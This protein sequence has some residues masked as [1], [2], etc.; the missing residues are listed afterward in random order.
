MPANSLPSCADMATAAMGGA[1][2]KAEE[3]I[4]A[5]AEVA[6]EME[7][8][9][10]VVAAAEKL[11]WRAIPRPCVPHHLSGVMR[12]HRSPDCRTPKPEGTV[13]CILMLLLSTW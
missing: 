1:E 6:E 3:A 2:E 12:W 11:E 10:M 8:E 7:E 4:A 13:S 5:R 9:E